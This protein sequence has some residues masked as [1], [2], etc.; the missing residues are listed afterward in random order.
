MCAL[1]KKDEVEGIR[2][3]YLVSYKTFSFSIKTLF[4]FILEIN[5]L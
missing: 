3:N 1:F 5:V 4:L 2:V